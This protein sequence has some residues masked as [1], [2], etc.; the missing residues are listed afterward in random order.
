LHYCVNALGCSWGKWWKNNT[1]PKVKGV[2]AEAYRRCCL[3]A[4]SVSGTNQVVLDL[5]YSNLVSGACAEGFLGGLQPLEVVGEFL[6]GRC[7]LVH[8]TVSQPARGFVSD[9]PE[10]HIH[11]ADDVL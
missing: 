3:H 10:R 4:R 8:L 2:R 1:K 6:N 7:I 5:G 11:V 9:H